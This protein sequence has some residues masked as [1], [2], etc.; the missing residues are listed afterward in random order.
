MA[1]TAEPGAGD[2]PLV[3]SGK[4]H[5]LSPSLDACLRLSRAPGGVLGLIDRCSRLDFDTICDVISAG[6][7]VNPTQRKRLVEPAVYETGMI[8]LF[9]PAIKFLRVIANGGQLPDSN[10]TQEALAS[11]EV[12][13]GY[14]G[15]HETL[16][17]DQLENLDQLRAR[18][19]KQLADE[20][21]D[22]EDGEETTDPLPQTESPLENTTAS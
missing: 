10:D 7:N 19:E 13:I 4:E 6:L 9:G 5:V 16:A 12:L 18:L 11:I 22:E 17:A 21:E 1:G 8:N 15:R 20:Q 3:L 2:V 14:L